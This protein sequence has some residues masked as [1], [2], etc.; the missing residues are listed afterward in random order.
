MNIKFKIKKPDFYSKS[1]FLSGPGWTFPK[2]SLNNKSPYY[3][4]VYFINGKRT[5]ISTKTTDKRTARRFFNNFSPPLFN[6]SAIKDPQKSISLKI[7]KEEYIDYCKQ[8]KSKSYVDCSIIPAF[9]KL[10]IFIGNMPLQNISSRILEQFITKTSSYSISAAALYYRT[11][12]A[13]FNK[14]VAWGYISEN[15][16]KKY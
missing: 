5:T 8:S 2:G 9:K 11:I 4:V 7:F 16:F 13:A 3:Q 6:E 1:S 12:K 10:G 15:P 14:A